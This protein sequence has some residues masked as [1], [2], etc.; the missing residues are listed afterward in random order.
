MVIVNVTMYIYKYIYI[1]IY[2]YIYI[3]IQRERERDRER[4]QVALGFGVL[5]THILYHIYILTTSNTSMVNAAIRH[6]VPF[7]SIPE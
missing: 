4:A 6:K 1:Y 7:T 3:Y 2:M 5:Q